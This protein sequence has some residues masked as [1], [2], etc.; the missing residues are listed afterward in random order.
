VVVH[1]A[2]ALVAEHNN[3]KKATVLGCCCCYRAGRAHSCTFFGSLFFPHVTLRC[4]T[5]CFLCLV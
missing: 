3:P 4:I 2:A 1:T 5:C